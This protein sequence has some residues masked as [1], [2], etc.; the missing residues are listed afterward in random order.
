MDFA[1]NPVDWEDHVH[2]HC[3]I[4][5]KYY[6]IL[7]LMVLMCLSANLTIRDYTEDT[8][9]VSLKKAVITDQVTGNKAT[10]VAGETH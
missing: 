7:K 8:L 3:K 4:H 1:N 9:V 2:R 10:G 5:F 6:Q